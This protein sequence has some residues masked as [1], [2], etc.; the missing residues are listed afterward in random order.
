MDQIISRT[1]LIAF[2]TQKYYRQGFNLIGYSFTIVNP[3]KYVETF[4]D[5]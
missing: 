2:Y 5:A 1:F 3:E 4:L